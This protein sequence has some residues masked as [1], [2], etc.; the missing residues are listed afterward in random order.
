[1]DLAHL[2]WPFFDESHR[3]FARDLSVWARREV[4]AHIDHGDTDR[5][6]RNLVRALGE[7]GWLRPVVPAA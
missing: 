7:A 2:E 1:M 5:S 4:A 6:C 3:R